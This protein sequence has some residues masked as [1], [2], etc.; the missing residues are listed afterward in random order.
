MTAGFPCQPY[1]RQGDRLGSMDSRSDTLILRAA[2]LCQSAG[3]VL[4][5]VASV[6]QHP[7]VLETIHRFAD[8]AGFV[9]QTVVLELGDQW[10]SRRH[11][12]FCTLLPQS[13]VCSP[14]LP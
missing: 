2:W 6:Q 8:L 14:L 1:S 7:T 11:R 3:L 4:E 12:W 13:L 5:C 10:A 9:V